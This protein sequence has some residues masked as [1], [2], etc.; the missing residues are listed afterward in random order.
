M[1]LKKF[2]YMVMAL[3]MVLA[4]CADYFDTANYLVEQPADDARLAY[5]A[6]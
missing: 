2:S 6:E 5:L 3:P 1:K 4:S